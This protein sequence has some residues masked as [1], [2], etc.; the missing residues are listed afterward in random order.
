MEHTF[1]G[2]DT[3]TYEE[4]A[5]KRCSVVAAS[6]FVNPIQFNQRSDYDLYPRVL[7]E[8]VAFCAACPKNE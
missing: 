6:I 3:A 7:E 4:E 1:D 5:R 2:F 8:D